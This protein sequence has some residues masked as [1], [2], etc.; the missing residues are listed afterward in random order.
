M[1]VGGGTA[2]TSDIL[3]RRFA[4]A[5][6]K[7]NRL[8]LDALGS[9]FGGAKRG[10]VLPDGTACVVSGSVSSLLPLLSISALARRRAAIGFPVYGEE[11][12][13]FRKPKDIATPLVTDLFDVCLSSFGL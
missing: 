1:W 8:T 4:C 13:R 3:L 7:P 5:C 9:F 2:L 6:R 10:V 12:G 11:A